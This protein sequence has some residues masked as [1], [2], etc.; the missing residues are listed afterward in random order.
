MKAVDEEKLKVAFV[1]SLNKIIE[2]KDTFIERLMKNINKV[3]ESRQDSTELQKIS[4]RLEEL[5][6]QMMN[7]VRLNVRSGLDNQIY[8]EEYERLEKEI[9]KLKEKKLR[10]DNVE[11]AK[12]NSIWKVKEIEK[13]LRD[14]KDILKE[15][16]EELFSKMVEKVRVISFVEVEFVFKSV[17][18]VKAVL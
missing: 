12:E 3:L 13:L 16:D 10:F 8:D 7:L 1:K 18:S 11:V 2:N 15:F 14:R 17:G 5:K 4:E 6:E 9:Q